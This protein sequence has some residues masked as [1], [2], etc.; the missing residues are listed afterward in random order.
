[1]R[2]IFIAILL[3]ESFTGLLA[4]KY[5]IGFTTGYS[6]FAMHDL[7]SSLEND[8]KQIPFEA[9][10]VS[11]FPSWISFGS[12]FLRKLGIYSI[13]VEYDFNSTG[14]RISS[15]DYSGRY[16]FDEL[17]NSHSFG[18]VNSFRFLKLGNFRAEAGVT[19]GYLYSTIKTTEYF[20][21]GDTS[22]TI[23]ASYYSDSFFI[24]PQ[25]SVTY[26]FPF[27]RIGAEFGYVFDKG[28]VIKTEKGEKTLI[29]RETDWS[30]YRIGIKAGL[31]PDALF[32]KKKNNEKQKDFQTETPR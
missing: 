22:M 27:M 13:G 30:G 25:L 4:Q 6:S 2:K 14:C 26:S 24:E 17:L 3:F 29:P 9:K 11:S 18:V 28:G 32:R 1:M 10:I 12:Y 16:N 21:L 5:E 23:S 8:F 7:K 19:M 15:V 20:Q 31:F